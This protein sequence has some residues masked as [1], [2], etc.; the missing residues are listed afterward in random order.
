MLKFV[1]ARN[2]FYLDELNVSLTAKNLSKY[3]FKATVR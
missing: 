1:F 3:L 2:Y